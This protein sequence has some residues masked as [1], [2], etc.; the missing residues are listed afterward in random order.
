MAWVPAAGSLPV[1]VLLLENFSMICFASTI[2]PLRE[3]N[4]V[5]KYRAYDWRVL[6]PDGQAVR[7]SN[8]LTVSVDGSIEDVPHCPMVIVCC[9]FDP[10][11]H[12]TPKIL[13]WLRKLDRQGA[14]IGGVET[15]AYVLARAGL[16]DNHRATIHW[17]NAD[18]IA[19]AFP[20]VK[21]TER[22]FEIDRRRFS[23][24]GAAATM[25]M[26]LHFI[27]LQVGRNVAH[28]V[29]EEFIYNRMRGA[30]NP[31][32]LSVAERINAR[33]PRLKRI[34][35]RIETDLDARLD[36]QQMA[37]TEGI[38]EREVR[39]LFQAYLGVS[40]QSYHRTL[41][42]QKARA[43]LRQTDLSVTQ[44]ALSC[45]FASSSDFSRAFKREFNR[46]PV[47]DRGEVYLLDR[48]SGLSLPD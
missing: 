46:T 11:L 21:L 9:S 28:G 30:E 15:G 13:S 33:H 45:G 17:E 20:K 37:A 16:L 3:A 14:Q 29:A 23:S 38:S 7:A 31:Q 48:S 35:Q 19:E 40:P 41:R 5:A 44:I 18:S 10:H 42:L 36:I 27:A 12:A 47:D 32:R 25:D 1:A 2:E 43:M 39:R 6:S 26:M 24:S 34:L 8:G 4:W 22:I